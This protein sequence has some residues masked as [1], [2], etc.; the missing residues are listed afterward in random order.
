[1]VIVQVVFCSL[2]AGTRD[3]NLYCLTKQK[4]QTQQYGIVCMYVPEDHYRYLQSMISYM[5]QVLLFVCLFVFVVVVF[6]LEKEM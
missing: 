1:M 3:I 6:L 4:M 2:Q 5:L